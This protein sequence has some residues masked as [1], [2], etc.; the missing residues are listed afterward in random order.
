MQSTDCL[1]IPMAKIKTKPTS[2]SVNDFI[3]AAKDQQKRKDSFVIFGTNE[4]SDWGRTE[5]VGQF[6]H[7]FW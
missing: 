1:Q 6:T 4:K 3:N 5:N 2:A 7:R